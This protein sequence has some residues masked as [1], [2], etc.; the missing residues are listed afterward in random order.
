MWELLSSDLQ[1][2]EEIHKRWIEAE[3]AGDSLAVLRLCTDDVL[4]IPPDAPLLEGKQAIARWLKVAEVEIESLEISGLRIGGGGTVAY[5]TANYTTAYVAED[6]SDVSS[7]RGT[8]LWVLR[9]MENHEWRVA[10]VS[11]SLIEA[12]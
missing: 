8:H 2:I 6:S 5:K 10:I 3:L 12:N 9:K 7:V 1:A 4:W 11:W